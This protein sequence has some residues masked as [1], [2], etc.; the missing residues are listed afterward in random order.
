[1]EL[2]THIQEISQR[3][4]GESGFV[5]RLVDEV[6][7]V[8]VGQKYMV[9]RL[10]VGLFSRGHVLLE[11]VPGLAKT[12]AVKTLAAAIDTKFQRIQFTPDLLPA[13]LIGTMIFN[14]KDGTFKNEALL[15]GAAVNRDGKAEATINLLRVARLDLL[16]FYQDRCICQN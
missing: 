14:Q 10:L 13:D 2:A 4:R 3:V 11:G 5:R 7:R 12:L 1:M 15:A 16:L 6:H 8:I 9:E